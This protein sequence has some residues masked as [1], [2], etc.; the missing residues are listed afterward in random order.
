MIFKTS[1]TLEANQLK[2]RVDKL[3]EKGA[4]VELK[5]KRKKVNRTIDQNAYYH[6]II[7]FYGSEVGYTSEEMKMIIK[8]EISP[9]IYQYEKGGHIFYK[10][11]ADLSLVEMKLSIEQILHHAA[12]HGIY[13]PSSG[14][15]LAIQQM[16]E[17]IRVYQKY[18]I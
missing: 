2:M 17:S 13:I 3:I 1:K 5:E 7:T 10:S 8:T 9:E 4:M 14:E 12:L 6:L 16:Q 11:S 15:H 18:Q